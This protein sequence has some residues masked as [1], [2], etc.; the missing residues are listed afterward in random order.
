MSRADSHRRAQSHLMST[1]DTDLDA[2]NISGPPSPPLRLP[3]DPAYSSSNGEDQQHNDAPPPTP[4]YDYAC[5][6]SFCEDGN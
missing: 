1:I 4:Y 3:D 5:I 6:P 2:L